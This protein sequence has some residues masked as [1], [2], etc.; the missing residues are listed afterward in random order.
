MIVNDK[1][2]PLLKH[3]HLKRLTGNLINVDFVIEA[4]GKFKTKEALNIILKWRKTCYFKC[5]SIEDDIK[6]VVLGCQ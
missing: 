2:I 6:T 4:T 3:N 5:S 1:K